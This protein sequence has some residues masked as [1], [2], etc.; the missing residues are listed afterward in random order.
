MN[1]A[2]VKL[3]FLAAGVAIGVAAVKLLECDKVIVIREDAVSKVKDTAEQAVNA[4]KNTAS[5]IKTAVTDKVCKNGAVLNL[6]DD[7]C[8]C[9]AADSAAA[10]EAAAEG[11]EE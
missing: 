9:C 8:D 2:W 5:Q 7:T 4:V 1:S 3:G 11:T 10:E 6:N